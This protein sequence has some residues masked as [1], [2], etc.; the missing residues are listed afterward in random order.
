MEILIWIF[1][2]I[3]ILL[4]SLYFTH[5]WAESPFS[6]TFQYTTS[7]RERKMKQTFCVSISSLRDAHTFYTHDM[8]HTWH[9]TER[10]V[11]S[12]CKNFKG[13][14]K[15]VSIHILLK[16]WIIFHLIKICYLMC[17]I[18]IIAMQHHTCTLYSSR[19]AVHCGRY[20]YTAEA[21]WS[22]TLRELCLNGKFLKLKL[23]EAIHASQC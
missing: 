5:H 10:R 20:S 7:H 3:I 23:N 11:H 1:R 8:R 4:L 21:E 18:I 9:D 19:D 17:R 2:F 15:T 14:P 12:T 13:N 6:M 16:H 22:P